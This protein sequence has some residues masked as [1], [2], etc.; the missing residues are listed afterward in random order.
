MREIAFT[1]LNRLCAYKMMEAR[2]VYIGGQK[3]R[4]AVSRGFNSNGVKFY[5]AGHPD[6]ERLFNTG[7][8]DI[9][10]RHFLDWLGGLLS[11]EIGVLFNPNDPANRLYPRQKTLDGVLDLLNGGGIKPD[12]TELREEWPKI[13]SQD[14]TIGWVYQYFTPKEMREAAKD[15]TRGGSEVPRNSY[16]LAFRNQFFTPRYVVEFLTDNTLG[17]IWYEMRKGET[18]LKGHCKYL[19]RRPNEIFVKEGEHPTADDAEVRRDLLRKEVFNLPARILHRE[20]KDPRE[21]KILDPACG[22]GH[23]LLYC[24]DLLLTIYEEAYADLDLGPSLKKDYPKLE[25][26]RQKV[27]GL[28]LTHNLHGIDI[29]VR[30]SQIAALA[31]WLR[32]QRAYY[33][34]G[35]RKERPKISRSNIVCAEP[36]PGEEHMLDEFVPQL[37]PRL[38][39]QLVKVVF[40]KMK[41]AGEAGSLLRI[42]EEIQDAVAEARKQWLTGPISVQRSLF[43]DNEPALKQQRF[44][45]S[46]ITNTQFFEHAESKVV[47]ALRNYAETAQSGHRL[48]RR[49]F[50]DDTV[51]GFAFVDLCHKQFD[52]VL[53]NPPFGSSTPRGSAVLH[54]DAAN[55]L[56]PAFVLRAC[57]QCVG[58]VGAITDRTFFVQDSFKHYRRR[59]VG[60]DWSLRLAVDL[61]WGV[62]DTADVQVAAYV[63]ATSGDS[64]HLFL[65]VRE[66]AD[67]PA[68]IYTGFSETGMPQVKVLTESHFSH[69]PNHLFAYSLPQVILDMFIRE[70]ALG[71][72]A[73]LPRGLGS[74]KAFRTYRA[75]FEVPQGHIG[76]EKRWRTLCNGGDFSPFFREDAG[77]ADWVRTDGT[78]LVVGGYADGM[79]AYD[80]KN[81]DFY[82]EPGLSFPKQSTL[83]NVAVLSADAIPTREGK[84]I[85]PHRHEDIWFLL[86]YLNS[87]LVRRIV[88][89]TTGLHK[90]SG[91]IGLVPVPQFS[92]EVR[93]SLG[94]LAKTFA[95]KQWKQLCF[96]E[97]SRFF[98]GPECLLQNGDLAIE[99]ISPYSLIDDCIFDALNIDT[100]LRAALHY[101]P[102]EVAPLFTA[103]PDELVSFAVGCCFGRWSYTLGDPQDRDLLDAI[104][105]QP[106]AIRRQ[107]EESPIA[108]DGILV[109]DSESA[110]DIVKRV[111]DAVERLVPADQADVIETR[112][113]QSVGV[114]DLREYF[115]AT[116]LVGFWPAHVDR[117]NKSRRQAPIYWL[118]QSSRKNYALWLYYHRFD[119][120]VLFKALVNYV[121]PK[122]RLETSRLESLRSEKAVA[123]ESSKEAKRLDR[124]IEGQEAEAA[125]CRFG[126]IGR[127]VSTCK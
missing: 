14:E 21:L 80:Q 97:T 82:F 42:E 68:A 19:V 25:D 87:S 23:F 5:L 52:V 64:Q 90:Q 3:F 63:V 72:I 1:H 114:S 17:R 6:D 95:E 28:I 16:E 8:Q 29:D 65:D 93:S 127:T 26:F 53:M 7:H 104:P 13:W 73:D 108:V 119:K 38:L 27:P 94:S 34:M 100:P 102:P 12:E 66:V 116:S 84:A 91:S 49:L 122:I 2:E 43:E 118:L 35:L 113:C 74:N 39:G 55:N 88:A 44:D 33:E 22:S 83:F 18:S 48:Q 112:F 125:Q 50:A 46:G 36:M 121:E 117:Y 76:A 57:E 101:D 41:L 120:D 31:L 110:Y 32:C 103:M 96:D 9:A 115:R 107:D 47:D 123:G 11:D 40:D 45:F 61:G 85:L 4:E 56:Y 106:P 75:W 30:A 105:D 59:L 70:Q 124:E 126:F 81:T 77:V 78:L 111:R 98:C 99:D 15:P 69:I 86:A 24:F 54:K 109:D 60:P 92:S 89:A 51:Q 71:D 37:E 20:K 58:F 62:L 67:K 79:K 10:Y